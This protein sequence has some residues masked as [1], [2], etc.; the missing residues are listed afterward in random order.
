MS[1]QGRVDYD[2]ARIGIEND[3]CGRLATD[4]KQPMICL[5]QGYIYLVAYLLSG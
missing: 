1:T 4:E 3:E 2:L 5:V